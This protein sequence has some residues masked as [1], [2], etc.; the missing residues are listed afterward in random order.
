MELC[1]VGFAPADLTWDERDL[2]TQSTSHRHGWIILCATARADP[3]Q[4]AQIE[5]L[6]TL[7]LYVHVGEMWV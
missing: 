2:W 1:C 4:G 3:L 6:K 5:A 7:R